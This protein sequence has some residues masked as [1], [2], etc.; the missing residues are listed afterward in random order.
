MVSVLPALGTVLGIVGFLLLGMAMPVRLPQLADLR[1]P[2]PVLPLRFGVAFG[3][4]VLAD[5]AGLELPAAACVL[6]LAPSPFAVVSL[7]RLYGYRR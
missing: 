3:A 5:A 1:S 4:W 7:S 6:A 2:V